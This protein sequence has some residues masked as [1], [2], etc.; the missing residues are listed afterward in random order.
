[1]LVYFKLPFGSTIIEGKKVYGFLEKFPPTKISWPAYRANK[2]IT[3]QAHYNKAI[4]EKM[5]PGKVFLDITFTYSELG[6]LKWEEMCALC[7]GFG[8]TTSRENRLRLRSLIKVF[9]KYC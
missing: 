7:K 5:F 3:I 8:I 4:L 2:K 6:Y 1:M 9:K